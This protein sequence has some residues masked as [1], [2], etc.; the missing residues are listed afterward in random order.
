MGTTDGLTWES[1]WWGSVGT[2]ALDP[3]KWPK[4]TFRESVDFAH[5]QGIRTLVWFEPDRV[6]D[7]DN[8][9]KNWGYKK[10]WAIPREEGNDIL[11][12][13][14][15]KECF[16]WVL[17]RI[18]QM[19]TENKIDMYREDFNV[20]CP[21]SNLDYGDKLQ[22]VNR[23]GI[24]EHNH[25]DGRYRLWDEIIKI[26]SSYG[27]CSFVDC[28]AS[29]GG[30][31][32]IE[33][34]RR[35]VPLLRSDADRTTTALRLSMTS[36]FNKWIPF[37]GANTKEKVGELDTDGAS[38]VY[39]WRASYLPCLNIDE[40][41]VQ[42]KSVDYSSVLFG[43]DEWKRVSPYLLKD[44]YLLTDW[45]DGEDKSGFTAYAYFDEDTK[46]GVIFAFRQ[47]D[48]VESEL[49]VK[50]PFANGVYSLTD[51]DTLETFKIT[52]GNL[53]LFFDKPRT[54]K[55]IWIKK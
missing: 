18:R 4:G 50:L 5:N 1:N 3:A 32:D 33:S 19:L 11:N 30:R 49:T 7:V 12:D 46:S 51:E 31:N 21:K 47:E 22:G 28:C 29:G 25:V 8:L 34:M 45:H 48:C 43:I 6:M 35:G 23:K 36:S 53:R 20:A 38:D 55:L 15:N 39:I 2:W 40:L 24:T 54:A 52:D 13:Y 10:E 44:F 14:G 17:G 27:G 42:K 9:V 41:F 26:T 37:C 16:E